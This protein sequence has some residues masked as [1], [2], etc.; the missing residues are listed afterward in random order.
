MAAFTNIDFVPPR[1]D[2]Q[3]PSAILSRMRRHAFPV[4]GNAE[5]R[6]CEAHQRHA[7]LAR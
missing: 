2:F 7:F 4:S 3:S 5:E 6:F 1:C